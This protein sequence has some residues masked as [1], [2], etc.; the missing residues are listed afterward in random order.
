VARRNGGVTMVLRTPT[1][2]RCERWGRWLREAGSPSG[3][4]G[5]KGV[6][7]YVTPPLG[8]PPASEHQDHQLDAVV[9]S[10]T[11]SLNFT[12]LPPPT[13]WPITAARG[14]RL[15]AG[16]WWRVQLFHAAAARGSK[17]TA[18]R[19]GRSRP[20]LAGV[21]AVSVLAPLL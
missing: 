18:K 14:A 11:L 12:W 3:T 16:E 20:R 2:I 15:D 10:L 13:L 17:I 1:R 9:A 5:P 7:T 4:S 8:P 21:F 19:Y 6:N